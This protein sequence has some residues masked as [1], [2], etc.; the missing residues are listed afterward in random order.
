[1]LLGIRCFG[2]AEKIP[3]G[4]SGP[5]LTIFLVPTLSTRPNSSRIVYHRAD[6]RAVDRRV[7][8][9]HISPRR[10]R[11]PCTTFLGRSSPSVNV[12]FIKSIIGH[13]SLI[14]LIPNYPLF[15]TLKIYIYF[16]SLNPIIILNIFSPYPS[17]SHIH[18]KT[19]SYIPLYP[20]LTINIL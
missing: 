10:S 20:H 19:F 15:S 7:P 9:V 11:R 12:N 8:S 3:L 16:I 17:Y 6:H 14:S 4:D 13:I 1:M 5:R 18:T 2:G